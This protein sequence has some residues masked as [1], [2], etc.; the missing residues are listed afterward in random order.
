V[1]RLAAG[2]IC[3]AHSFGAKADAREAGRAMWV[4][5]GFA[6]YPKQFKIKD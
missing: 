5:L 4:R 2:E 6:A 1:H 3:G